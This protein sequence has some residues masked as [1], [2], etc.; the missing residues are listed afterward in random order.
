MV[1]DNGSIDSERGSRFACALLSK[2]SA[3]TLLLV[4]PV[5]D[6]LFPP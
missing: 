3:I 1:P 2:E 5:I 4:V 6:A